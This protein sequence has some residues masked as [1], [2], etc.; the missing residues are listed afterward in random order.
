MCCGSGAWNRDD[1][2]RKTDRDCMTHRRAMRFT[3]VPVRGG[4]TRPRPFWDGST[5]P[6]DYVSVIHRSAQDGNEITLENGNKR[7]DGKG[8]GRRGG[9][10]EWRK[11]RNRRGQGQRGSEWVET[12]W[13]GGGGG[14]RDVLKSEG[15]KRR[16][17]KDR[18]RE[19][20]R[21][22]SRARP[23]GRREGATPMLT[24]SLPPRFSD[25]CPTI[26]SHS[27]RADSRLP[28]TLPTTPLTLV[29]KENP[30]KMSAAQQETCADGSGEPPKK[31][32]ILTAATLPECA[33]RFAI[34]SLLV[35]TYWGAGAMHDLPPVRPRI[36][37]NP[38]SRYSE[39]E[40]SGGL[41]IAG[42]PRTTAALSPSIISQR[43]QAVNDWMKCSFGTLHACSFNVNAHATVNPYV[44]GTSKH[45][46]H[47]K[48]PPDQRT[49]AGQ[50]KSR[51][52]PRC[53]N[54]Q[55]QHFISLTCS[56][57]GTVSL[58]H[59]ALELS[60]TADWCLSTAHHACAVASFSRTNMASAS[61]SAPGRASCRH[62]TALWHSSAAPLCNTRKNIREASNYQRPWLYIQ[63]LLSSLSQVQQ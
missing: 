46:V 35:A 31:N 53:S 34:F 37:L 61:L 7:A 18:G 3:R 59:F 41:G 13:G 26:A 5:S 43:S 50:R 11:W 8:K 25:Q 39:E 33:R 48:E 10:K 54:E 15:V 60:W 57:A 4:R 30:H 58:S 36:L 9:G 45:S 63:P 17:T 12:E 40:R 1:Q 6:R 19:G 14:D 2:S 29:C 24:C 55:V 51:L 44:W 22:E 49:I 47:Q 42:I 20:W 23:R 56:S 27:S 38:E 62:S 21:V 32:R 16:P 28:T 52:L